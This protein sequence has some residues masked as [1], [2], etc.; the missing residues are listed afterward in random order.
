[1]THD[2]HRRT[3]IAE[4]STHLTVEDAAHVS[5]GLSFDIYTLLVESHMTFHVCH[6]VC[7]K[8]VHDSI[9][10]CNWEGKAPTVALKVAA[11]LTV[12]RRNSILRLRLAGTFLSLGFEPALLGSLTLLCLSQFLLARLC[13][14]L[15]LA[16]CRLSCLFCL[17]GC[18][19][20]CSLGLCILLRSSG[21]GFGLGFLFLTR[22][23]P[24]FS[25]VPLPAS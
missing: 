2:N 1:M 18:A 16:L 14:S 17:T 9:A 7:T 6:G 10:A 12:Y 20:C 15:S 3:R 5:A 8:A 13:I 21:P 11:H 25:P 23:Q 24:S 19:L 22:Q 4:H